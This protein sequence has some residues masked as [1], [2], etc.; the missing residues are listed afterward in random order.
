M[1]RL[2][3]ALSLLLTLG[4]SA[5]TMSQVF[6]QMPANIVPYLSEN[7]RLDM[8]D[9]IDS[10]MKAEVRNLY[11]GKS[12]MLRMSDDYAR[13]ALSE[14]SLMEMRL[15]DVSQPV[16]STKKIL[17]VV[18]TYGAV[19]KDSQ[20]EF[21]SSKWRKLNTK[22]YV[23]LP[24]WMFTASLDEHEPTLTLASSSLLDKPASEEQKEVNKKLIALKWENG[25]F[26]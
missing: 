14:G 6:K 5:Q 7:N 23:T 10:K 24:D 22:Q 17:C 15:L 19:F 8:I 21:Y 26:K 3:I 4:S 11:E 13:L 12:E 1:R 16:D 9:F 18:R 25:L 20:V 2:F